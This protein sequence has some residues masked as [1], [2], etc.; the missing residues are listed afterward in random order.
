MYFLENLENQK[1]FSGGKAVTMQLTYSI[2]RLQ[3]ISNI[4]EASDS[5]PEIYLMEQIFDDYLE[6]QFVL[7]N[8]YYNYGE[9][10]VESFHIDYIQKVLKVLRSYLSFSEVTLDS[11]VGEDGF[12]VI[13]VNMY[14][15]DEVVPVLR[16]YPYFKQYEKLPHEKLLELQQYEQEQMQVVDELEDQMKLLQ[17]SYNNPALYADGNVKLYLK[18]QNKKQREQ[19]LSA[20]LT[21][22][23]PSLQEAKSNLAA[24]QDE[25]RSIEEMCSSLDIVRDRYADRLVNRF[26][27]VE[28]G[29]EEE[30]VSNEP[31]KFE[32]STE[33]QNHS[34]MEFFQGMMDNSPQMQVL[35]DENDYIDEDEDLQ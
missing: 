34:N 16:I 4:I 17:D 33:E 18:M 2:E 7:S 26:G 20:E 10:A 28:I 23:I 29:D 22:L 3:R 5:T 25:I 14:F 15:M 9:R 12:Y 31:S 30:V 19:I 32:Q 6:A 8:T 11:Q 27:F 1:V 13:T 24:I 35:F 21:S